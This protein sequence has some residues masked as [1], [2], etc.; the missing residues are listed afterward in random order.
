MRGIHSLLML[1][2]LCF[3]LLSSIFLVSVFAQSPQL[4]DPLTIPQFVNQLKQAPAVYVPTNVTD[5]A[6]N[7]IRQDYTVTVSEFSQ[8]ILPTVNVE[9]AATGYPTTKFWGYGGI[10]QSFVT[11]E[12]LGMI[13]SVPG[14]TFEAIQGIPAQ[15]KWVNALTDD[16]GNPLSYSLPV[17]PTLHWANPNNLQMDT[18]TETVPVFPPGFVDAQ[19]SVPIVTHLHGGE[20]PSASDGYP[21]AWWTA[22]GKHGPA[23]NT[24]AATEANSAI[25]Y[26]PNG[27]QP[28]TLWYHDHA[29]GL[30]RL[31]V[32]SGLAGFYL[33]RNASDQIATLLPSGE[34]E[35]PLALQDRSFYTDGSLYYPTVG[36][37]SG[38]HPYWQNFFLGNTMVV[39]GKAWPNMNV[40][41]GQYRFRILDASNSRFYNI[42]FSNSMNFTLIG[43]DG[44]Y[45]K[46]PVEL[47]SMLIAPAERVDI[48]VDFSKVSEGQKIILENFAG[49]LSENDALTT[50]RIMQFTV[51][52]EKGFT[53]EQLPASLNPTLSGNF[54]TLPT[55]SQQRILTMIDVAGPNGSATML[56]D[57]QKWSAPASET[58]I[59]GSI[60]DWLLLNPTI[61]AHPIHIHL[62]QFQVVKHQLFNITTYMEEWTKLNGN[63]PLNHSTVNVP[64]LD[65]YFMG[66]PT[67]PSATEEAWK[68]TITVHSGEIVFI[69][70]RWTEQ[71]GDPFPFDATAGP[72]YVW[73]CHL[74]EHED[75]EMMRQYV[76][77]APFFDLRL[78]ILAIIIVALVVVIAVVVVL[79]RRRRKAAISSS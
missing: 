1:A 5:S 29:L 13:K 9:G 51:T 28:T 45:V 44:G 26:Y 17:D 75:N 4:I 76:V 49:A 73:H 66:E 72:G 70:L 74:L 53:P 12:N 34:Y 67:G 6:G 47:S 39:N 22:D 15:V 62:V 59:L 78:E 40:K 24:A 50:G 8:Q 43:T 11:G 20:N 14:C 27:Q 23:Y 25:F 64:A 31:N 3:L 37:N 61:D 63:A 30:T 55:P 71:N 19:A 46:R 57:G 68:D 42:S 32:L 79:S 35:M 56:L 21:E 58:P 16:A 77:I 52:S 33:I 65:P 7:L 36:V 69:R 54:P 41:Q 2:A 48:L 60:E 18:S 10:A 38:I